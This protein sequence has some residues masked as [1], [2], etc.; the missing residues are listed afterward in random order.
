MG[1]IESSIGIYTLP[2]VTHSASGKLLPSTGGSPML[3]DDFQG[4][5]GEE[6]GSRGRGYM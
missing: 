6:G 3:R 4:W 1:Q 2:R 5:D